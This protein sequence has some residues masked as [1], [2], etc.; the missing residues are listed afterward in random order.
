[1]RGNKMPEMFLKTNENPGNIKE[2]MAK[3]TLG[4]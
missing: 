3:I 4:M 2:Q 1:V